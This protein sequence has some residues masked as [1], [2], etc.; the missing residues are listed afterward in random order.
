MLATP[1]FV[2][3]EQWQAQIQSLIQRKAR[4]LLFSTLPDEV[5]KRCHLTPCPDIA[6]AVRDE[7]ARLGPDAT[8]AVLPQGP[9]TIPYL[10][11]QS[12]GK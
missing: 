4:V 6:T 7:L 3:P 8:V 11:E 9:L 12:A 10:A 2:R 1:G 5:V